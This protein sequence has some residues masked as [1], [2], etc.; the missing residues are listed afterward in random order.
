MARIPHLIAPLRALA[1]FAGDVADGAFAILHNGLLLVGAAVMTAALVLLG[2]PD[3]LSS[4]E[5]RL[6]HWLTVRE[7]AA[8]GI[9]PDF[10]AIARTT[11]INPHGLAPAQ[12]NIAHW[13]SKKYRV[14][15]E[16]MAALVHEAFR[17]GQ[18]N[19]LE[20]TL[21]LAVAAIESSFNPFAQSHAGA[22]GLMQ[23]MTR[24]HSDKYAYF[25]GDYAAFD[26]RSNLRVGVRI[27]REYMDRTGSLQTGL[28]WYV[29]AANLGSDGGYAARVIAEYRRM[30]EAAYGQPLPADALLRARYNPPS[31]AE[32]PT[33]VAQIP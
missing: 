4:G 10:A 29:G 21:I 20:P 33:R 28:K 24:V 18:R 30:Y 16:P 27:L 26:P 22:Q 9:K 6:S 15:P 3:L 13:I 7:T 2:N 12:A 23:V 8:T 32:D 19:N 11:A 17:T 31:G 14:A 1:T 5:Q 25:G